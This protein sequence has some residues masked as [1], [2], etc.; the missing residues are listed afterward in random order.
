V[1]RLRDGSPLVD[2]PQDSYYGGDEKGYSDWPAL[3]E[4]EDNE[5]KA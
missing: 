4:E 1:Q 3:E 5:R 2:A